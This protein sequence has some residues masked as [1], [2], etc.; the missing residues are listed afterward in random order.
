MPQIAALL[1]EA[2][3]CLRTAGVESPRLEARI[4]LEEAGGVG[5]ARQ[6]AEPDLQLELA[7]V[8]TFRSLVQ[9]RAVREPLAYILGRAEFWSLSYAIV[10]GVLVPRPETETLIEVAIDLFPERGRPLR[11][12][13]IGSGSG[14]VLLTLLHLFPNARGIGTDSSATARACATRNAE[15]L[16]VEPRVDIREAN[17]AEGV[18]GPFDLVLSNPPYIPGGEIRGLQPEVA[19]YEPRAALDGGPDGLDAYRAVLP[20]LPS[21]LAGDGVAL[22]E[23]G[24]GQ[25]R[26]VLDLARGHDLRG[27]EH[28]DLAGIVRCIEL[29]RAPGTGRP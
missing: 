15:R 26:D 29:R 14:C 23:I 25:E 19:L 21:L 5:R 17:F 7:A 28:P 2:A 24:K 20:A 6:V 12:L 10:P 8:Q 13:D 27:R 11:I 3:R 16:A 18:E 22:L 4:L 1:E 9:R